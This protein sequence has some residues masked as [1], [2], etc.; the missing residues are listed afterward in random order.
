MGLI[1]IDA[2]KR[3][4]QSPSYTKP[5]TVPKNMSTTPTTGVVGALAGVPVPNM[6]LSQPTT[7]GVTVP[8]MNRQPLPTGLPGSTTPVP[9]MNLSSTNPASN[10]TI[11]NGYSASNPGGGYQPSP[12]GGVTLP[13]TEQTLNTQSGLVNTPW[14]YNAA[15]DQSLQAA[16]RDADNK[17]L[18]NQKNTNAQLRATGQGKSSYSET[19]ANQ[20]ANQSAENIANTLVPQYESMA[21]QKNQDQIGNL[22]NLY[23]DQYQQDVT[24]PLNE[25][26]ATGIYQNAATK[27]ALNKIM[28]YKAEAEGPN[29]TAAR[30]AEL[31]K[32]ADQQRAIID[33]N[34]GNSSQVGANVN[35]KNINQTGIGI[36]TLA[37]Q[38]QDLAAQNQT[39]NQST[40]TRQLDTADKQYGEQFAYTKARDAISDKRWQAEFDY[41]KEQGG[42]DYALRRLAQA[43]STAYQQAQ[44]AL[45]QD[46][47]A[48]AWATLDYEQSQGTGSKASG[49]S[50]N[51]ILSSMQSLY[52]E[53]VYVTDPDTG[54]QTKTGEKITADPAKRKQMFESVVDSGLSDTETNQI[55][56][57]LGMTKKEIDSLVKSYSG[58]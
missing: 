48:R 37:G 25:S 30:R 15:D 51:Q 9:N 28:F 57:S 27:E 21:Y 55:L 56:L 2:I 47:N 16:I 1:N 4:M 17:L 54:V 13:R 44:L 14:N 40:Q 50:P 20:L 24:T 42:L 34:G 12:T 6:S 31:S 58:N 26:T 3:L 41:N 22:R 39:F 53:P 49:L 11:P 45:S 43:D 36:R 7:P 29:I 32:L 18:I 38:N 19:V 5:T 23:S 46:D 10:V 52:T 33:A 8:N 35:S